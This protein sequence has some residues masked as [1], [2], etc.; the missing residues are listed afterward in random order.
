MRYVRIGMIIW[1][2]GCSSGKLRKACRVGHDKPVGEFIRIEANRA[3]VQVYEE[4]G[5][6]EN[7]DWDNK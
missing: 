3:T 7:V 5:M 6:D 1:I 2:L 4:T